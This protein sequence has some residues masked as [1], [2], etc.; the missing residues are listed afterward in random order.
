MGSR[1]SIT[2]SQPVHGVKMLFNVPVP[3]RDG[4]NLSADIYLPDAPGAFPTVLNRTPYDNSTQNHADLGVFY[5]QRGYVYVVQDCRG[6]YDSEGLFYAYHDDARDG[7]DT[8]EWI[9]G[10]PWC[11]GSIGTSGE[12]YGGHTQWM[13]APLGSRYLKAMVPRVTPSDIWKEDAYSAGVF[14]LALGLF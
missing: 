5:A 6:R 12:S 14:R 4:V 3:M 10:Q 13:P 11:N 1:A 8:Q 2:D 9:G 7:Y